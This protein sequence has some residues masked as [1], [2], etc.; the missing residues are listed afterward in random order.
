[1]ALLL[2][3]IA[4]RMQIMWPLEIHTTGFFA[5]RG[6]FQLTKSQSMSS[7]LRRRIGAAF[8]RHDPYLSGSRRQRSEQ[9]PSLGNHYAPS[10]VN[11]ILRHIHAHDNSHPSFARFLIHTFRV[12]IAVAIVGAGGLFYFEYRVKGEYRIC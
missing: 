1:M 9:R 6:S 12:P 3:V 4:L 5:I 7:A 8:R 11:S 2:V 10:Y